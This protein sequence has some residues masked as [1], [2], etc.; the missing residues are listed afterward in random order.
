MHLS[1]DNRLF[2]RVDGEL[3]V[4]YSP[5]GSDREYCT[6][7]KNIS[8]GGVR[9]S[10]LKKLEPGTVLDLEIFKY[11][12]DL[13][14]VCRGKVAWIWGEPM[15][16]EKNQLFEAGISFLNQQLLYIGRLINHLETQNTGNIL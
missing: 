12:T 7:T 11:N 15:S 13:K 14:A 1:I 4:R 9:M 2:A 16:R 3:G 8:G 5:Q 10:L 6:T